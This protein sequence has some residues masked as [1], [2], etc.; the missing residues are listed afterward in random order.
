MKVALFLVAL[1]ALSSATSE[2]DT[3]FMQEFKRVLNYH[4]LIDRF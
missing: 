2:E 1:I 4:Y 3:E